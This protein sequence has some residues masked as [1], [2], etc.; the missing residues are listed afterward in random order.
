VATTVAAAAA[1]EVVVHRSSTTTRKKFQDPHGPYVHHADKP[2]REAR[3]M[4]CL[5]VSALL[6]FVHLLYIQPHPTAAKALNTDTPIAFFPPSTPPRLE[7]HEVGG[8]EKKQKQSEG[9]G[10]K[11]LG[12]G[13]SPRGLI[14][15]LLCVVGANFFGFL[16]GFI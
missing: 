15:T 6:R 2:K 14:K 11:A 12:I 3:S 4:H 16:F 1:V 8:K 9:V 10:S 13:L 5:Y 7:V